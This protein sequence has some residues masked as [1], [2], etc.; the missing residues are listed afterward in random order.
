MVSCPDTAGQFLQTVV[1]QVEAAEATE[2]PK[3]IFWNCSQAIAIQVKEAQVTQIPKDTFW[4]CSQP[5]A[6][7][8][9][10]AQGVFQAI[11]HSSRKLS[12]IHVF[13]MQVGV[14]VV[15]VLP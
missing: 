2:I 10:F 9:K 13:Q 3:D 8:V 11:K 4:K 5:V 1:L 6:L 14:E 7:Q 15:V 12:Q